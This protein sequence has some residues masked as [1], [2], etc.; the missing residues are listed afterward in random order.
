MGL[1][2]H[3]FQHRRRH[4][5]I[6]IRH[7]QADTECVV[8]D[9]GDVFIRFIVFRHDDDTEIAVHITQLRQRTD[10]F[11]EEQTAPIQEYLVICADG[12]HDILRTL[13]SVCHD[14]R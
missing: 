2:R 12:G 10:H 1:D 11:D 3:R 7:R 9:R 5:R 14:D 13:G 8:V 4:L 6:R